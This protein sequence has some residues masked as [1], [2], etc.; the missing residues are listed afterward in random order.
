MPFCWTH[1][2]QKFYPGNKERSV[3]Y[4]KILEFSL[5]LFTKGHQVSSLYCHFGVFTGTELVLH[6]IRPPPPPQDSRLC[7]NY[8]ITS[9]KHAS[10]MWKAEHREAWIKLKDTLTSAPVLACSDPN[11]KL[12]VIPDASPVGLSEF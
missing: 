6:G 5:Q 2:Q 8:G 12:K 7:Y 1:C 10:F 4:L 11:R 9:S 3:H